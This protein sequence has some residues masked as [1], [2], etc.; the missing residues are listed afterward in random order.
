M[1]IFVV[2]GGRTTETR[3]NSSEDLHTRRRALHGLGKKKESTGKARTWKEERIRTEKVMAVHS[4]HICS[5]DVGWH[6]HVYVQNVIMGEFA[7]N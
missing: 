7:Q 6:T 2:D 1:Q 4:F 3:N 5:W